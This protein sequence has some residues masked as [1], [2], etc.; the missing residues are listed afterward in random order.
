M[1]KSFYHSFVALVLIVSVLGPTLLSF[2]AFENDNTI[3]VEINAEENNEKEIENSLDKK[4]LFFEQ[5]NL[6]TPNGSSKQSNF[7]NCYKSMS[8]SMA[9]EV[10]LPPP[11]ERLPL[12]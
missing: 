2:C 6:D 11:K 8:L 9:M 12:S 7:H 5:L 4:E 1:L 10:V 3:A